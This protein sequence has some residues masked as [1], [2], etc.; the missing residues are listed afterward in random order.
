MDLLSLD[1]NILLFI[2]DNIRNDFLTPIMEA[3]TLFASFGGLV[4]I[5]T[6]LTLLIINKTRRVGLASTIAIALSGLIT[7]AIIKNIVNRTRPY[8]A[9]DELDPIGKLPTDSSFPSGHSS[10]AFAAA[11]AISLSVPFIIEKKKAHLIGVLIIVLASLIALSR[12]YLGVHYP[13]DVLVGTIL[14]VIYGICGAMLSK[15]IYKKI[16]ERKNTEQADMGT[17]SDSQDEIR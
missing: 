9:I 14:G 8:V 4:W 5:I 13:S 15:L 3:V 16:D 17:S 7:N 10:V 11:I 1:G 2:Q 12:L 6:S